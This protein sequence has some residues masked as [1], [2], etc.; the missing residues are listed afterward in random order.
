VAIAIFLAFYLGS[1]AQSQF[2]IFAILTVVFIAGF[3]AIEGL[4]FSKSASEVSG[5]G[6]GGAYQRQS[7]LHFLALTVTMIVAFLLG[8]GF[9]AYLGLFIFLMIFLT[10]SAAN[11]LYSGLKDK[12]VLNSLLRPVLTILLWIIG[13]YFILP[14]LNP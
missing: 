4:F 10:L 6:E 2:N 1:N 8:W 13:I 3:T 14:A 12:F 11:H 9:F 5:Y 7:T